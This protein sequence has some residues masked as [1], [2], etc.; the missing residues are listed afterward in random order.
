MSRKLLLF[1]AAVVAAG[2]FL[3]RDK[4]AGLL[5][6]RLG[7]AL[8]KSWLIVQFMSIS[9]VKTKDKALR[10]WIHREHHTFFSNFA[11][12]AVRI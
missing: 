1:G 11:R 12:I 9:L 7:L 4:V 10:K 2:V 5:P 3:K 8:L 6:E